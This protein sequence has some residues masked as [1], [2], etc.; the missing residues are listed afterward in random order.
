MR[1]PAHEPNWAQAVV[2]IKLYSSEAVG[3][4][5][6]RN[7]AYQAEAARTGAS[8]D[9]ALLVVSCRV[10][11][12]TL[13]ELGAFPNLVLYDYDVLAW[14]FSEYLELA[15]TFEAVLGETLAKRGASRSAPLPKRDIKIPDIRKLPAHPK[16]IPTAT[17]AVT[18]AKCYALNSTKFLLGPP[19]HR[20]L[21]PN[22]ENA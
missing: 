12:L 22:A 17:R 18:Q 1:P 3:R 16:V 15:V 8:A 2:E 21:K 9:R 20:L 10:D 5:V 11:S 6:L 14:L 19:A 4:S 13:A 7:A